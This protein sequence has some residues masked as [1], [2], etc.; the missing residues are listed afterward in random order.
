MKKLLQ[1]QKDK[2]NFE[3][4]AHDQLSRHLTEPVNSFGTRGQSCSRKDKEIVYFQA[5][6][7]KIEALCNRV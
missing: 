1:F 7:N 3:K 4:Q 2:V 6:T 5:K